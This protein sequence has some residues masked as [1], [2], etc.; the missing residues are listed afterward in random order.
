MFIQSVKRRTKDFISAR[1][2][3]LLV[4]EGKSSVVVLICKMYIA[5]LDREESL[6]NL[7]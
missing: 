6:L 4:Q 2:D 3:Q 1:T 5:N 7:F